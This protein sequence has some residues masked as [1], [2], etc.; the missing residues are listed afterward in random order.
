MLLSAWPLA[1]RY[2]ALI[3]VFNA[4]FAFARRLARRLHAQPQILKVVLRTTDDYIHRVDDAEALTEAA[5]H[6]WPPPDSS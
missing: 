5:Q 4:P 1:E 3:R 6:A 2:E